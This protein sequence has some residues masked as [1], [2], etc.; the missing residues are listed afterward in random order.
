ML[1]QGDLIIVSRTRTKSMK[2]ASEISRQKADQLE[3]IWTP[4]NSFSR[5]LVT[6]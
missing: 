2:N 4:L 5:I 6:K 1:K 3:Q